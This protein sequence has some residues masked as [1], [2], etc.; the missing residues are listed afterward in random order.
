LKKRT[1][2]GI[3]TARAFSALITRTGIW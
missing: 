3:D 2:L 1:G